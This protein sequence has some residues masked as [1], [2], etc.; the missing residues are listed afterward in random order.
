MDVDALGASFND[1]MVCW[2]KLLPH[3]VRHPLIGNDLMAILKA[4]QK[5]Y[6]G[7]MFSG[8]GGGYLIVASKQKVPGSLQVTVRVTSES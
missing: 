2:E 6:P 8:C 4:Y 1:C 5:Q 3:V 7:A